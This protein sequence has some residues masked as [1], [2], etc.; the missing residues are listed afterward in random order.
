MI[1]ETF[2]V[3]SVVIIQTCRPVKKSELVMNALDQNANAVEELVFAVALNSARNSFDGRT[4]AQTH[5]ERVIAVRDEFMNMSDEEVSDEDDC[6]KAR[7]QS[8]S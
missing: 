4:S 5:G 8:W 2:T 3:L 7:R 6:M 1:N